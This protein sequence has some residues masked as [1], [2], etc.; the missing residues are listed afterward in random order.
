[1]L[2]STAQLTVFLMVLARIIGLFASA[3]L[4][5]SR[6]FPAFAKV[7]LAIWV[8]GI[9]WFVV[10][11]RAEALPV[12]SM[13]IVLMLTSE[14][15]IG[16]AMGFLT[17]IIFIVVQGAG[18]IIDMQ[19]GLSVAQSFDPVFGA[20]I[21]VIGRMTFYIALTIFLVVNGH[22]LLLSALNQS[23]R[24]IPVGG[25][26]NLS[27]PLLVL[28]MIELGTRFWSM[29]LQFAGPMILIIFLSDFA[30]GIV[31]RVAPQVNVFM[32]G[33]QVKPA[34][35][36]IGLMFTMPLIVKHLAGLLEYMAETAFKLLLI[37]R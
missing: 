27:S 15:I 31:S 24:V 3:P 37:I 7:A 5:N 16:L 28:Q 11:V 18:E 25:M 21:S 35:G 2:I 13:G 29:A 32:L 1:M 9:L 19:M 8:A 22:H 33:F 34:L 4:F 26:I 17:N 14:A 23:F 20:Q 10:P 12:T 36:L 30:F 6:S